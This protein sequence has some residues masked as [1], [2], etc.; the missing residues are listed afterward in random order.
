MSGALKLF[1]N[2]DATL[3][4]L[5]DYTG[6]ATIE[7]SNTVTNAGTYDLV[8]KTNITGAAGSSFINK[9]DMNRSGLIGGCFV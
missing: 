5:E 8:G 9:Q 6:G 7:G 4:G 2:G 3:S 1:F